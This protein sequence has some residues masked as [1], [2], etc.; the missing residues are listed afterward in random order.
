VTTPTAARDLTVDAFLARAQARLRAAGIEAPW[1]EA[2]LLLAHATGVT[3]ESL[4]A[5]PD[6][7][8]ADAAAADRL[9]ERRAAREPFHRLVGHREFWGLEFRL[10]DTVLTP[11]P[12]TETVVE[13]VLSG[14][15]DPAAPLRIMD[16]GVG[17]GCLLLALLS[18]L[19]ESLGVGIDCSEAALAVARRNAARLG[20]EGRAR[21]TASDWFK[22]ADGRF[23]VIVANPPYIPCAEIEGLEPEVLRSTAG[24]TGSRPIARSWLAGRTI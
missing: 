4:I 6:S 20:L 15:D 9:V 23:D 24:P 18:A 3:P 11:R 2:R 19:P 8:V 10:D 12:D 13:A 22:K 7:P 5:Y 17:S 21:F 14:I 16:L 1:R